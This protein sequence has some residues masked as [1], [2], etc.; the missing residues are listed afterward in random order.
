M[1]DYSE[2]RQYERNEYNT[3]LYLYENESQNDYGYAN[4]SEY[5]SGGMSF[6][7]NEKMEI[8][9]QVYIK[10]KYYDEKSTGPEKYSEYSGYIKWSDE[11]GT[12]IPGGQYGYGIQYAEPVFY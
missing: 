6:R 10:T 1:K 12:S 4:M 9:Q 8:G 3:S 11:L 7:T 5:S 2:R